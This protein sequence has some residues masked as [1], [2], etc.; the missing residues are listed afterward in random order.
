MNEEVE[1][2]DG[3]ILE[4]MDRLHVVQCNIGDH[5]LE[6][7]AIKKADVEDHIQQ[8]LDHLMAAYQLVSNIEE[9]END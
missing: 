7:P 4:A 3:F 6:H 8:A 5:I 2:N 1:W 9:E